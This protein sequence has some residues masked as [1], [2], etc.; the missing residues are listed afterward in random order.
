MFLFGEKPKWLF[1]T[2]KSMLIDLLVRE[3][4]VTASYKNTLVLCI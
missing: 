3:G 1:T 4:S 2:N